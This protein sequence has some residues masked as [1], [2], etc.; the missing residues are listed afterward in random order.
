MKQVHEEYLANVQTRISS[1]KVSQLAMAAPLE[2][3]VSS[4]KP[5]T[6]APSETRV[7]PKQ[8]PN[9][10]SGLLSALLSIGALRPAFA[11]LSKFPWLVDAYPE[12]ADLVLRILK[13][14]LSGLYDSL[15]VTKERNMSF[16][17]PRARYGSGGAS[18]PPP[19]KPL[20]S[21][22]APT[23]PSTSTTD[24]VFF[25]PDWARRVPVC[26]SLGDLVD[27]LE[28][29]MRFIGLH[30]SRDPLFL[31]KFL[32][33][34]RMHIAST[35]YL[36]VYISTQ[37]FISFI[38]RFLSIWRRRN[39]SGMPT[40]SIP[41]VSFGTKY[42]AYISFPRSL[43][44]EAMLSALSRCGTSS[45]NTRQPPGGVYTANGKL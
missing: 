43:S 19:R 21:L 37:S 30:V 36:D 32:R 44:S 39:L 20:L 29:I 31:T 2:S 18:M 8:L 14:S 17:Q 5:K 6:T 41:F 10:K 13:Q 33:L 1:A 3:V 45:D 28:P 38:F 23:P 40:P 42:Y 35:V 4:S 26:S 12:I 11:I 34:G 15:L 9:Q 27:V 24:F 25:F 7:E 22:S 16:G